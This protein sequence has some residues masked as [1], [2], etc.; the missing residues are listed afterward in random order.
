[1]KNIT[2]WSVTVVFFF[3]STLS[4]AQVVTKTIDDGTPGT[5]RV[6]IANVGTNGILT[7]DNSI[8]GQ[9]I[10]L[11][12]GEIAIS[13]FLSLTINGDNGGTPTTISGTNSS[14]IFNFSSTVAG[15]IT[16]NDV[17]F[18]NGEATDGGAVAVNDATT[19]L[20]LTDCEFRNNRATGSAGTNGG[21]ALFNNGAIVTINGVSIFDSN[22]ANGTSGSGGAILNSNGGS[23]T[24]NDATFNLNSASRAGG[25]IEDNSG[26]LGNLNID[27]SV[28]TANSTGSNPGNGGAIHMT[29]AGNST[30]NA[31][32]FS[33]NTASNEGG[34]LW[35]GSGV[36]TITS[37]TIDGNTASGSDALVAGASGGG[38]IYNEG[39]T[40]LTDATTVITNNVADG[41]Q[42]T[43]G[44]VLNAN[45][46]FTA[47]GSTISSNSSNRAGGGIEQNQVS[48]TNLTDVTMSMNI[49]GAV[50]GAGAP[51]NGGALHVSQAG[52]VNI[53]NGSFT[54]N[55]ASNEGGGLW[56]GSG[57]MNIDGTAAIN[58]NTANGEASM[59][60]MNPGEAGGG[61]IYNEGG[62]VVITGSVTVNDNNAT[63]ST[64]TGGGILVAGGSLDATGTTISGNGANR[65]GG[66]IEANSGAP[67]TLTNVNLNSNTAGVVV[68]AGAPGNGG[69]LH[70]SGSSPVSIT[71]GTVN[72]N[73]AMSEGGG[74]WNGTGTMTVDGVTLDSNIA[75]GA[76]AD[77]GGGAV[78]AL[79]GGTVSIVNG[80]ILTNNVANG[81]SGSGGAVLVDA[82]ASIN[83]D[84]SSLNSNTANRAGGAIE[85]VAG[86]GTASLS[87][88]TMN[89][90]NAGA[91]PAIAAPGNGGALH[92][93]GN[94]DITIN[95]SG[96]S[97]NIAAREGGALW[98]GTGV[99]TITNSTIDANF[100][101]GNSADDGGAGIFN[102]GGDVLADGITVTNNLAQGTS[103]SGGAVLSLDGGLS[104]LNSTFTGN[105][106]NRAGG[107]FEIIDGFLTITDCDVSSNDV[108]GTAGTPA[109]GNG[110]AIHITGATTT[111]ILRSTFNNNSA[112][113]EGGALWN[114]NNSTMTVEFSTLDGNSAFGTDLTNDGGGAIFLNGGDFIISNST[115]S[116]NSATAN[117]GG[118]GNLNGSMTVSTSTIS[119]NSAGANGGGIVSTGP[120]NILN[121]VTV[122]RNTATTDAGG[123]GFQS[124]SGSFTIK[125][126]II[127]ENVS[128]NGVPDIGVSTGAFTSLGFN[129]IEIDDIGDFTP[130]ATDIVGTSA[131]PEYAA[132]GPLANNGGITLTHALMNGTRA[133]DNGDSADTFTDQIGQAVF[134]TR[135]IGAFESQI[136]LS[137]EAFELEF[138]ASKLYPNPASGATVQL[139]LS[140]SFQG[141][142]D[143]RVIDMTG[144]TIAMNKVVP[145][146]NEIEVNTFAAGAYIIRLEGKEQVETLRLI[147]D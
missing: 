93:T 83:I 44:G 55:I 85:I 43:G 105:A 26:A 33:N 84:S 10:T 116:N 22:F 25:A 42:G 37:T 122:A 29:G 30:I 60:A 59:G 63:G 46:V 106:A 80:S 35:N 74:L 57:V 75:S 138:V 27:S 28:F 5:L 76:G 95:N 79:N 53:T 2:L 71:G 137:N 70:I 67:V 21:G 92:I 45:G 66:G 125:N 31:S 32:S 111:D 114:Q 126:S 143:Y 97:G 20:T 78:Y 23:L 144:K 113:R 19:V 61:G 56:N 62:A 90:N 123:V 129:L 101:T 127:A 136:T 36:M 9:T 89:M 81:A 91:A 13:S 1:M 77:N 47:N 135:D 142:I 38:G 99:M 48:T 104:F 50:V 18:T 115:I 34:G 94:Q 117:G 100:A 39:G 132:L 130:L 68:G 17:I 49:T 96:F 98:N 14:R 139:E 41:A 52:T 103:G 108:N 73:T 15:S 58:N 72:N 107:A 134:G 11:T 51:G 145:G 133:F 6:E 118:I 102:N 86:T 128:T 82:D 4:F 69:G 65:A 121:A 88:V 124:A 110:G 120:V 119:G 7:F 16:I 140:P 40:V 8:Q 64:S 141:S 3:I 112:G 24:V 109:P 54:Q 131:A 12:N 147:V 146:V 87:N